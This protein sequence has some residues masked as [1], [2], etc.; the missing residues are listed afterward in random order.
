VTK[1]DAMGYEWFGNRATLTAF[2][3]TQPMWKT[4][5]PVPVIN[6]M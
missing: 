2:A 3:A 4:I 6:Y 5:T 1:D